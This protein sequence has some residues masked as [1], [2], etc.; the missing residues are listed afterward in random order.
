MIENK[1]PAYI[2]IVEGPPPTFKEVSAEWLI[3]VLE[4]A[5]QKEIALCEMR[6]YDGQK[7]VNRCQQAWR[8][9]RPVRLDFPTDEEGSRDQLDVLA[10]RWEETGE[11]HK[12][13][14]W[15]KRN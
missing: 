3:G 14:L 2:T 5:G 15:L 13:Y 4:G 6:A 9:G 1:T 8:E 7:L 12:L 10:A 11:Y